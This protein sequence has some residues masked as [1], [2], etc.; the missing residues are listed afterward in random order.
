MINKELCNQCIYSK[1][2]ELHTESVC[3]VCY[4]IDSIGHGGNRYFIKKTAIPNCCGECSHCKTTY[5]SLN[6]TS[7]CEAFKK[8]DT[9]DRRI[10]GKCIRKNYLTKNTPKWCPMKE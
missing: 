2:A 1:D 5:L 3:E 10:I 4:H 9:D 6:N 8:Y 7:Y